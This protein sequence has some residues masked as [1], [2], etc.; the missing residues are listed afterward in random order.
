[1]VV[2]EEQFSTYARMSY[3]RQTGR[4]RIV[5][6]RGFIHIHDVYEREATRNTYRVVSLIR[7]V[8][9]W[10]GSEFLGAMQESSHGIPP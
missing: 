1:V 9:V 8:L 3:D 10:Q 2:D 4:L 5:F 6:N 7:H